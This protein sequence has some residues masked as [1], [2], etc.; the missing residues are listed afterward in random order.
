MVL[1][2]VKRL[3]PSLVESLMGGKK[4]KYDHD[5]DMT[6]P[7]DKIFREENKT[8]RRKEIECVKCKA[9]IPGHISHILGSSES[10]PSQPRRNL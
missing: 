10:R 2:P 1:S 5:Q 9:G 3:I 7:E 8:K 6:T 4:R